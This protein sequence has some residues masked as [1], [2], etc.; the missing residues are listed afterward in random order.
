MN[1]TPLFPLNTV[2]FP[3]M[4]ITLHIFEE[5]YKKMMNHCIAEN[6][7]FGVVL[8]EQGQ[9][10]GQPSKPYMI[11]CAAQIAQVQPLK[12]GRMNLIA[13]GKERFRIQSLNFDNPYLTGRISPL[14]L[15]G[16]VK[17]SGH[18]AARALR[19]VLADYLDVLSNVGEVEFNV[20]KIPDDP[21]ELAYLSATLLQAPNEHKQT[22]LEI[23]NRN[24]L[25]N[26]VYK[27]CR[28]EISVLRAMLAPDQVPTQ[29]GP[30]SLN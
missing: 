19:A 18:I 5:R 6:A 7:P 21:V 24:H 10:V 4:P 20:E 17:K 1:E 9:E 27:L 13:L 2:L 30:F 11:G 12:D 25:I 8:I 29:E 3:N 26:E 16:D 28:R 22:L 23:D 14:P 15:V